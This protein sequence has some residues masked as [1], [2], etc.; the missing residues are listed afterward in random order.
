MG[1]DQASVL[2]PTTMRVH[3]LEGLRVIDAS[4][5]PYV[6]NANIYAP[7]MMLA[8]KAADL[9]L[10]NT[11]LPPEHLP[12]YRHQPVAAGERAVSDITR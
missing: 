2:D 7:V 12:F 6:T 3:G 5:M 10:G 4:A 11:P 9:V 1:V 8:E